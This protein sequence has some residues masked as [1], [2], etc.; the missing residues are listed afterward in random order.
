M[1]KN[2]INDM[3]DIKQDLKLKD[4]ILKAQNLVQ[5][6]GKDYVGILKEFGY[7]YNENLLDILGRYGDE[8]FDAMIKND[9]SLI[10]LVK[11]ALDKML[12]KDKIIEERKFNVNGRISKA[13]ATHMKALLEM[14]KYIPEYKFGENYTIGLYVFEGSK[15]F[16]K[17]K[18]FCNETFDNFTDINRIIVGKYGFVKQFEVPPGNRFINYSPLHNTQPQIIYDAV[19]LSE[20]DW[21][22][23]VE[24]IEI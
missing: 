15:I 18:K 9:D 19:N 23:L 16:K 22:K 2:K 3:I 5:D 21:I 13:H 7:E 8:V 17:F 10:L 14:R 20:P 24:T 12:F 1:N 6:T 4:M 11:G